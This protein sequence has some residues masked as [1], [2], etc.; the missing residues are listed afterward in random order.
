MKKEG[1]TKE[2]CINRTSSL[3]NPK[4]TMNG[5]SLS[6]HNKADHLFTPYSKMNEDND[7]YPYSDDFS[8]MHNIS[9]VEAYEHKCDIRKT[10]ISSVLLFLMAV[11]IFSVIWF[12][13]EIMEEVGNLMEIIKEN[14]FLTITIYF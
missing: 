13:G 11:T 6:S 2:N 12:K 4:L 7:F 10:M 3:V 14:P 9:I 1:E 8:D 5:K